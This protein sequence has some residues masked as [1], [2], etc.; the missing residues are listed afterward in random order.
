MLKKQVLG[1]STNLQNSQLLQLLKFIGICSN[2]L[3]R[4]H[5]NVPQNSKWFKYF[6]IEDLNKRSETARTTVLSP[7]QVMN[8]KNILFNFIPLQLQISYISP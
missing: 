6:F 5:L 3:L 2:G 4:M 1:S 8:P 7:Y